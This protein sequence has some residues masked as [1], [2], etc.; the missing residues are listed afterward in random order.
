MDQR[1]TRAGTRKNAT[2]IQIG[3]TGG[4]RRRRGQ[5][6]EGVEAT[7]RFSLSYSLRGATVGGEEKKKVKNALCFFAQWKIKI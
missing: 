6:E 5:I 4:A 1:L 7:I 3:F 2:V